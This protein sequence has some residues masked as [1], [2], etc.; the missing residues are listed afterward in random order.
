MSK[1]RKM[2]K[3]LNEAVKKMPDKVG[4]LPE[5]VKLRKE[6]DIDAFHGTNQ[7]VA[8][9]PVITKDGRRVLVEEDYQPIKEFIDKSE[10]EG[11]TP[12]IQD[13]GNWFSE[14]P[15]V[16]N[17]FAGDRL[18]VG[19]SS[20]TAQVYPV[21]LRLKNPKEY[22]SYEELEE[23]F[24]D[25]M[26]LGI[27]EGKSF[28][29]EEGIGSKAFRE[30]LQKQGHDGIII[31]RATT[32]TGMPRKDYVVFEPKNIRSRFAMFDPKKSESGDIMANI[33]GITTIGALA[34][35]GDS[36]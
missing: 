1:Y 22:F 34:G 11:D 24:E 30:N 25:F 2:I 28:G 17:F 27:K 18:Y 8:I 5:N 33:A 32:D 6:F 7:D 20:P 12:N 29:P 10:Y 35:L 15:E 13:I 9:N 23:E 4:V 26:E 31:T 3:M 36:T 21:K 14:D 19:S 16:A